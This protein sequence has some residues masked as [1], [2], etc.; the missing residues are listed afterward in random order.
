MKKTIA[1]AS[2]SVSLVLF[3][4]AACSD[5][6]ESLSPQ[7]TY[8]PT[9]LTL[10]TPYYFGSNYEI[11]PD[12]PT[13]EEGVELGRMLF[14]E[15]KLSG[16]NTQ[17]CG[18]CHQQRKAFTDGNRFSK[19]IEGLDGTKNAM[20][21][22]NLLWTPRFFWDGRSVSLE[23]QALIPIQDPIEMHETLENA[24]AKLQATEIYPP[25]FFAAFGSDSITATNIGKALAQFQRTLISADSKYDR[26]LRGEYQPTELEMEGIT[27]FQTHPIAEIGL[28]GGNC[29]D[30]HLGALTSGDL[31]GFQGFHNNGLD[32]DEN[33]KPGLAKVTGNAFDRGKFKAPTLRNI[34][35]TAPYMHD[36]RFATLE[37]VLEH[38]DQHIQR[39]ET[40]DPLIIEASNE[41]VIPGEPIKLHL[42]TREKEA[43][44]SFLHMLTDSSF[45]QNEKFSNPFN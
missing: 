37:E 21:L 41:I 14:Y 19:G 25:R 31:N 4:L 3:L 27:L 5:N 12:N 11:P 23:E 24:V 1:W 45:I 7:A 18:S 26:Y 29:G 2:L 30:C 44:L 42:T 13:T 10:N 40:L 16:D 9:L 22:A 15:K 36:G 43:I 39:S 17:S 28:R 33:L 32:T 20:S 35:L 38:Y 6:N 8:N 34:A